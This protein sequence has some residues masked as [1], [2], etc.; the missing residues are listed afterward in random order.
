MV[1]A[2]ADDAGERNGR[3]IKRQFPTDP[4]GV[5]VVE[6][7]QDDSEVDVADVVV[8]AHLHRGPQRSQMRDRVEAGV[9]DVEVSATRSSAPLNG[10]PV[11]A[12]PGEVDVR[13]AAGTQVDSTRIRIRLLSV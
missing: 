8:L 10:V 7:V 5:R 2:L 6:P 12:P 3:V 1:E 9:R 11:L 13:C 4:V